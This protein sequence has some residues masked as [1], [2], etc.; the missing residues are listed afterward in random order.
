MNDLHQPYL[1]RGE[2]IYTEKVDSL[3]SFSGKNKIKLQ[4]FLFSDISISKARIF[5]NKRTDSL[6]VDISVNS[7]IREEYSVV[8]DNLSEGSFSFEVFTLDDFGNR[9]I[10]VERIGKS[11][12]DVY[13]SSLVNR[14]ISSNI[15]DAN[16]IQF[17]MSSNIP[18]DYVYS[19]FEYYFNGE[20]QTTQLDISDLN[21][22]KI[23]VTD[24]DLTKNILFR[25]VYLPYGNAID[26]F[27]T[28]FKEYIIN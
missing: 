4:W 9:S 24:I 14:V 12:G 16:Y 17:N 1:D 5:W 21:S 6:D 18:E 28:E 15:L 23:A 8:I 26:T 13:Q 19:E 20:K 7:N 10:P 11:L 22:F 2:I 27:K 25:S 3:I